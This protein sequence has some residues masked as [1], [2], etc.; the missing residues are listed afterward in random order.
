MSTGQ[1]LPHELCGDSE[2]SWGCGGRGGGVGTVSPDPGLPHELRD[3]SERS[4][5]RG[6]GVQ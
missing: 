4:W 2:R 5:G 1:D 6:G 3:D